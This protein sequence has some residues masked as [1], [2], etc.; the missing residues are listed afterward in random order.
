MNPPTSITMALL[1][2]ILAGESFGGGPA[3]ESSSQPVDQVLVV[4]SKRTL[5]LLTKGK[6]VRSY[7]VALGGDSI[8]AKQQ[9]GD[10]KTP[11]GRYVLD[12][13]NPKS[14]FYKSIHISYPNEQDRQRAT[15]RGVAPGGDVMIHGL[16]NGFGWLGATHRTI[17]WTDGCI[18]VT[19]K[20]MD[21][22]WDLVRDGTPV[23]IQP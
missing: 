18:A 3:A 17:D 2:G 10:H 7:K 19:D 12:R 1:I 23:E 21:E 4:K 14:R 5:T 13:R 20:E 16:P 6:V 9:Q 8:G 15:Q 22:V 11:E